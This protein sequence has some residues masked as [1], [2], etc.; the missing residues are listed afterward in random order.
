MHTLAGLPQER[1][2]QRCPSVTAETSCRG[3]GCPSRD[4]QGGM[5]CTL[6]RSPGR[7]PAWVQDAQCHSEDVP[8]GDTGAGITLCLGR[9]VLIPPME[10]PSGISHVPVRMDSQAVE[11]A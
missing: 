9:N 3:L 6:I 2:M 1:G 8:H 4:A 11:P 10:F 5:F 7:H